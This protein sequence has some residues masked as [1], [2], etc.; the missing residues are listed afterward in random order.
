M[1]TLNTS[2]MYTNKITRK[3][4]LSE[5]CYQHPL[6]QQDVGLFQMC[7]SFFRG[8]S[9]KITVP[10]VTNARKNIELFINFWIQCSCYNANSRKSICYRMYPCKKNISTEVV[11]SN[12]KN[13][14]E[15]G[16]NANTSGL[17]SG[18]A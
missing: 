9:S 1:H 16:S 5:C 8:F 7:S 15:V 17:Q 10:K 18:G 6:Y 2:P 13:N 3:Q 14:S 4:F 12:T 11:E